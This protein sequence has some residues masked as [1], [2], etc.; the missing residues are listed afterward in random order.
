MRRLLLIIAI[1]I[2]PA[3]AAVAAVCA[4]CVHDVPLSSGH[5]A[6][7]AAFAGL[8]VAEKLDHLADVADESPCAS[9]QLGSSTMPLPAFGMTA[10]DDP[11]APP[12]HR[13]VL[14]DP[15]HLERIERVP[16]AVAVSS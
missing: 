6:V 16:L 5:G 11:V 14:Y 1:L 2:I 13:S 7:H 9:C 10:A 8:D 3:Q 15:S 12:E 4:Y